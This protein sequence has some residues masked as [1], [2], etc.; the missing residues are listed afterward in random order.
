MKAVKRV[1][2]RFIVA[3]VTSFVSVMLVRLQEG[4]AGD[5]KQ[6]FLIS[7]LTAFFMAVD[8]LSREYKNI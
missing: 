2:R 3:F 6:V 5:L 1:A 8:K 4:E 7:L